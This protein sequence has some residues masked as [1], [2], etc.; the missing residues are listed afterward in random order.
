MLFSAHTGISLPAEIYEKFKI[1]AAGLNEKD[2]SLWA[3]RLR[4]FSSTYRDW[5]WMSRKREAM[6][7]EWR[8]VFSEFDVIVCPV[9]PT[10]AFP[11]DHS[12]M[13]NRKIEVDG[14]WLPYSNQFVWSGIASVF[15]L[16]ATSMPIGMSVGGLPIGVQV[17]GDYL[18]DKTTIEFAKLAGS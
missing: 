12:D 13:E 4:G 18:Q 3:C 6:R 1:A 5:F 16:P 11:H 10:V 2:N 15:G 14:E 9:M 8:K 7:V 17:I